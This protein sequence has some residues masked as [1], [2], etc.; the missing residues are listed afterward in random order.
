VALLI[1]CAV[2]L[3]LPAFLPHPSAFRE[4]VLA[5]AI[6]CATPWAAYRVVDDLSKTTERPAGAADELDA[7]PRL[8]LRGVDLQ[9]AVLPGAELYR[10]D[11]AGALLKGADLRSAN[12]RAAN[13]ARGDF[14]AADLRGAKLRGADLRGADLRDANLGGADLH[15]AHLCGADLHRARLRGVDFRAADLRG[16]KL[17]APSTE[18]IQFEGSIYDAKTRWPNDEPPPGSIRVE[19]SDEAER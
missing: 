5:I 3:V 19:S 17:R 9:D 16:A 6:G 12:L 15:K 11:L 14:R 10:C 18:S 8:V 7:I 4:L 2:V 13:C 1:L